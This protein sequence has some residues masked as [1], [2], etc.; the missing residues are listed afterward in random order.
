[1]KRAL[2]LESHISEAQCI[3]QEAH[4]SL[5][6]LVSSSFH[7]KKSRLTLALEK[8]IAQEMRDRFA[9]LVIPKDLICQILRYL[10]PKEC[11]RIARQFNKT[12]HAWAQNV[13]D[14]YLLRM[15][16]YSHL[17]KYSDR[18]TIAKFVKQFNVFAVYY[19][20]THSVFIEFLKTVP[21]IN[22][23]SALNGKVNFFLHKNGNLVLSFARN[24]DQCQILPLCNILLKMAPYEIYCSWLLYNS[25]KIRKNSLPKESDYFFSMKVPTCLF[26]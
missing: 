7:S 1:M 17:F 12:Y 22:G 25:D 10:E 2:F 23:A 15:D 14:L 3:I 11:W 21:E 20:D 8:V 13:M 24:T 18:K 26:L 9:H 6:V 5:E 4:A 19:K 16:K